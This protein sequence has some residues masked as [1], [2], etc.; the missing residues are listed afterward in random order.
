MATLPKLSVSQPEDLAAG[1]AK[2]DQYSNALN[3]V[4]EMGLADPPKPLNHDGALPNDLTSLEDNVLGDLLARQSSWYAYVSTILAKSSSGRDMAVARETF[5][6][7]RVRSM[8]KAESKAVGQKMTVQDL[9]DEVESHSSVVEAQA[10]TLYTEHVWRLVKV[11]AEYAEMA[12]QTISRRITQ[13]G[14]EI[15]RMRR[16]GNVAGVPTHAAFRRPGQG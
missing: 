14:Q 6:R 10:N 1:A 4:H 3:A 5:I 2:L 9:N 7:A 15:D 12:W 8:I 16:E 13:R 11:H